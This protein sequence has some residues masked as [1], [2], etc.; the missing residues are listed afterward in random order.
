M[1]RDEHL[2]SA[3]TVFKGIT[4]TLNCTHG[5]LNE[6]PKNISVLFLYLGNEYLNIE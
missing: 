6:N 2:L 5:N 3:C 1:N 4:L